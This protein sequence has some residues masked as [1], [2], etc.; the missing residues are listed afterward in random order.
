MKRIFL[1]LLLVA[2]CPSLF[3][4]SEQRNVVKINP[5]SALI[6][7]GAIFYERKVSDH[8]APQMG[9]AYMQWKSGGTKL[10]GVMITPEARFYIT[11]K[12]L[13]GI[14]LAPYYRYQKFT[15][16][17]GDNE[18]SYTSNGG[19]LIFG[20]QWIWESGFNLDFFFG[21]GMNEGKFEIKS[22]NE[23]PDDSFLDGFRPR[24]G[25]ALGFA[26]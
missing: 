2:F 8:F 12:A 16:T 17:D 19:G 11:G 6:G 26:F 25:L 15:L 1:V 5:L 22:G 7:T 4:Q 21:A 20:R 18:A 3:A 9:F 13:D 10:V 14:Y 24:I 23:S